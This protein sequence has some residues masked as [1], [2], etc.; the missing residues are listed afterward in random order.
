[1]QKQSNEE[2]LTLYNQLLIMRKGEKLKSQAGDHFQYF[3]EFQSQLKNIVVKV[4]RL[5]LSKKH[6]HSFFQ[7]Q[8]SS[9]TKSLRKVKTV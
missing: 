4:W 5:E 2:L 3:S 1:M 6:R 9:K 8:Y 7:R